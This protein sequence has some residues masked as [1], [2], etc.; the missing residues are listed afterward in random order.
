MNG[1]S[2]SHQISDLAAL[3]Q[4]YGKPM[5]ASIRKEINYIHPHYRA[6]IEA[7][8]FA[9]LATSGPDGLDASPRGD[10]AGFVQVQDEKTLLLSLIH[11]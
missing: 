6:F 8:P 2:K 10:P 4:I 1:Q 9:V 5:A 3:E 11:I 7:A